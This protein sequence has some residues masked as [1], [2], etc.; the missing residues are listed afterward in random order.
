MFTGTTCADRELRAAEPVS[1]LP[2]CG[3]SA[4]LTSRPGGT[5]PRSTQCWRSTPTAWTS[6]RASRPTTRS[7]GR[8]GPDSSRNCSRP[9]RACRTP[10]K[11]QP[12]PSLARALQT[13]TWTRWWPRWGRTPWALGGTLVRRPRPPGRGSATAA[14]GDARE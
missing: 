9:A 8:R 14:A 6:R 12:T 3:F 11:T 13:S 2:C 7:C 5:P 4:P 1:S 10:A